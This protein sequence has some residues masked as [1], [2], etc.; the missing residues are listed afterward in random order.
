MMVYILYVACIRRPPAITINLEV[1][2][3]VVVVVVVLH[4]QC[5]EPFDSFVD[6]A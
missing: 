6:S 4:I 3:I 1:V 5:R 2:S